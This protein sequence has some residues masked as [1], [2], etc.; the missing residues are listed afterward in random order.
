MA[1]RIKFVDLLP[2]YRAMEKAPGSLY[3]L[4]ITNDVLK[5]ALALAIDDSNVDES[6]IAVRQGDY[7]NISLGDVFLL[8]VSQPR[9]GLG[10]LAESFAKYITSTTGARVKERDNYYLIEEAFSSSDQPVNISVN[11]YRRVLRFIGLI[12]ESAHYLD[13]AK[14]ELV[15]Y[16]DGRF[17]VPLFYGVQEVDALD[18][19]V[20]ESLERF[21]LDLYHKEQKIKMLGENLI[22]MLSMVPMSERFSY[23]ISHLGDLYSRLQAGYNL[24]AS[25]YTYEKAVT[26][27]HAFKVDVI[28]K[29]HKAITD[30]QA[31]VLGIPIATFIALSQLK[32]TTGLNAQFAANTVIFFGVMVFCFLLIGFLANQ[33]ATLNTINQEILRQKKVFA[34]RFESKQVAYEGEFSTIAGRLRWQY[35]AV[36]AIATLDV[37]M[38]CGSA[39]YYVLHTRPIYDLLF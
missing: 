16:K 35:A 13:S 20:F 36:Y 26:E 22:E 14:E 4:E 28:T 23:L 9:L 3:R 1:K 38:F 7:E 33:H 19:S 32:K 8:A 34:K 25:D 24:F 21:V 30:I 2:I 31:Q 27:V 11:R 37:L 5:S 29:I 15:F 17:V 18:F 12:N 6:G 39:V 10:I